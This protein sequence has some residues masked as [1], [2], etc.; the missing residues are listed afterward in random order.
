MK[1]IT[2][3]YDGISSFFEQIMGVSGRCY[4]YKHGSHVT[5]I[6]QSDSR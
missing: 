2:L 6:P 4:V 3:L 5:G 1:V